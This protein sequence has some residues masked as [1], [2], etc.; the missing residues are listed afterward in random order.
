[1]TDEITA[2]LVIHGLPTM[3]KKTKQN[4]VDWLRNTANQIK[5]EK[6]MKIFNKNY[7]ATLYK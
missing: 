6:D 5:R 3:T 4:L 2:R 7:R 1:M